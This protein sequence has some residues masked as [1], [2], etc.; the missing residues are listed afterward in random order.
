[1]DKCEKLKYKVGDLFLA[2]GY[3]CVGIITEIDEKDSKYKMYWWSS[4]KK[5]KRTSFCWYSGNCFYRWTK[6]N[7]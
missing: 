5:D 6:L 7:K 3:D 4:D 2:N 1:M